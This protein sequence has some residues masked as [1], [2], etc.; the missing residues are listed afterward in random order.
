MKESKVLISILNW[1]AP[2]NTCN[3]IKSVLSS[4]YKHYKI[5]ILD[6]NS[7]DDSVPRIKEYF[8]DIELW[9]LKKKSR[10]CRSSQKGRGVCC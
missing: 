3:T 1:N 4:G 8:P 6:N 2:M 10:V 9:A 5:I 7:K